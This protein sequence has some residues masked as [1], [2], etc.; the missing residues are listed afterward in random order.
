MFKNI[1]SIAQ[2]AAILKATFTFP[3]LDNVPPTEIVR[4]CTTVPTNKINIGMYAG[5][6]SSVNKRL[7]KNLPKIAHNTDKNIV[8]KNVLDI[9]F[10]IN[11]LMFLYSFFP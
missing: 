11:F 10:F 2:R 6:N 3:I 4:V 5:K 1:F 9:V 7:I 8:T